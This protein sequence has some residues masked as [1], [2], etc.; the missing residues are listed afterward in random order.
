MVSRD[1]G[2]VIFSDKCPQLYDTLAI[3]KRVWVSSIDKVNAF[4]RTDFSLAMYLTKRHNIAILFKPTTFSPHGRE[5][6]EHHA[7]K[8]HDLFVTPAQVRSFS[9]N[10]I[11]LCRLRNHWNQDLTQSRAVSRHLVSEPWE[12]PRLWGL[13][14]HEQMADQLSCDLYSRLPLADSVLCTGSMA[15]RHPMV[16]CCKGD[17][18]DLTVKTSQ[19]LV[20]VVNAVDANNLFS[21]A[22]SDGRSLVF[23][24][25]LAL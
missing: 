16:P 23:C 9:A 21:M 22:S 5:T 3:I 2:Y 19:L 6:T 4:P 15:A 11:V 24:M 18:E 10:K 17:K 25:V 20:R 7:N 13:W 8:V 1:L 14:R 12:H